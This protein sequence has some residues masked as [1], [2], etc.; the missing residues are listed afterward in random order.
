M[1]AGPPDA[2]WRTA[3]GRQIPDGRV[4]S[5]QWQTGGVQAEPGAGGKQGASP[6]GAGAIL[7]AAALWG[8]TGTA[9]HFAPRGVSSV[10]VGA[11][12]IVLAGLILVLVAQYSPA[13]GAAAGS[14]RGSEF[15]SLLQARGVDRAALVL[16]AAAVAGYQVCFFSAVRLTGVAIGTV[17]AI[18]SGPVFTGLISTLTGTSRLSARWTSA[19]AGAVLG[20][21]IL[22]AGGKTAGVQLAGAGLA[23]L[24]GLCYA[25]YAVAAARLITGGASERS[26]MAIM[27]G[28][29]GL[30]LLPVLL[31]GPV[32]WLLSVRGAAVVFELG[33]LATAIAYL[34]YG[35]GLR[36]VQA[37]VAVTL[38]LAEPAVASLLAVVVLRE[39]LTGTAGSGLLLLCLALVLLVIPGRGEP[40]AARSRRAIRRGAWLGHE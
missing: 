38:G 12:R 32:G 4:G 14:A 22:L 13:S 25:C 7:A 30:V 33:V 27:F 3:D 20:C 9:A 21:S 29:G 36:T 40:R 28:G 35:Y 5:V 31:A 39:R 16:G 23:L 6:G 37:P 24:A 34:L 10:S 8:S 2:W 26:V 1:G 11:A 18:G 19:T 17:V 15:R